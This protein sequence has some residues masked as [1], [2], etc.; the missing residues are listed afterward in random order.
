MSVDI[1]SRFSKIGELKAGWGKTGTRTGTGTIWC[2]TRT[3]GVNRDEDQQ[4]QAGWG[5]TGTGTE[6]GTIWCKTG[7]RT[8]TCGVNRDEDQQGHSSV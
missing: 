8:G 7:T 5:K 2:K 6:T 1:S 3:W 4:G